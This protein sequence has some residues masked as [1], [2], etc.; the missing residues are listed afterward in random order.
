ML[1]AGFFPAWIGYVSR[2]K[3]NAYGWTD[4]KLGYFC[5]YFFRHFSSALLVMMSVEKFIALYFPLKAK[6][7]CTVETAKWSSGI[8]FIIFVLFDAQFF[9][10]VKAN[11]G[12]GSIQFCYD[13][14]LFDGYIALYSKVDGILYS[15]APFAIMSLTNIA[16]IYK[17]VK[18]KVASKHTG[19]GSTN[20][21]LSKAATKGTA[22]LIAVSITFIILTG[23]ANIIYS[24]TI[25]PHPLLNQFLYFCIVLNHSINGL[26]Y[27][28]VGSKFRKELIYT[29]CCNRRRA[30]DIQGAVSRSTIVSKHSRNPSTVSP[31]NN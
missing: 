23:P 24:I 19:T 2:S 6:A 7:I 10:A 30:P 15:F 17:F 9:F 3:I 14:E 22:I 25:F 16:I 18:A 5:W 12:D 11:K 21:A 8:A 20:Q 31:Q 28:I 13:I 4:C 27:C 1:W 26:L 29:L